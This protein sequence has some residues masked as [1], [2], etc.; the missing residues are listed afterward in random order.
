MTFSITYSTRK[1]VGL[2]ALARIANQDTQELANPCASSERKG[3]DALLQVRGRRGEGEDGGGGSLGANRWVD[4]GGFSLAAL[5]PSL[6]GWTV[7]GQRKA[8]SRGRGQ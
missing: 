6:I 8:F 5:C 7:A 3:E 4:D 1:K 2:L